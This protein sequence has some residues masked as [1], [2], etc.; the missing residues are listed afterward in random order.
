MQGILTEKKYFVA[1]LIVIVLFASLSLLYLK[2][3]HIGGDGTT[4]AEAMQVL[5]THQVPQGFMPNRIL[6][7][8]LGLEL[9]LKVGTFLG[10]I[11]LAWII[12]NTCFYIVLS[13]S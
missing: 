3:D 7:T 5:A 13:V 10:N 9:I 12:I 1:F 8:F 11:P 2:P 6:T 4:Y